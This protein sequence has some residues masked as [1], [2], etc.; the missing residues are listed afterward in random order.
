M[1]SVIQRR[2]FVDGNK[3]IALLGGAEVPYLAGH[4]F[5]TPSGEIVEVAVA[6]TEHKIEARPL[7]RWFEAYAKLL[8]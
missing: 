6:L 5:P 8:S 3:R 1:E 7:S 2:P 4:D